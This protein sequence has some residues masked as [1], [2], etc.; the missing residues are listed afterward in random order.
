M[1]WVLTENVR[2]RRFYEAC[3]GR[4]VARAP[5][6]FGEL[7]TEKLAYGWHDGLPLPAF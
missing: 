3:G 7:R 1:L 2:G 4:P 6:E 5:I